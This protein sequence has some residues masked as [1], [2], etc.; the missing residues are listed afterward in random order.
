MRP[1]SSPA[2]RKRRRRPDAAAAAARR[3]EEL[4]YCSDIMLGIDKLY[5]LGAKGHNI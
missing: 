1:G 4:T 3:G 2:A 5:S